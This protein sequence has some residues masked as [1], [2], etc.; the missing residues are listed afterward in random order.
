MFSLLCHAHVIYIIDKYFYFRK[1]DS[2]D[3]LLKDGDPWELLNI[4]ID[5]AIEL[6]NQVIQ[7]VKDK[8]GMIYLIFKET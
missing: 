1:L 4:P 2:T 6:F 7:F 3:K 5:H 8:L